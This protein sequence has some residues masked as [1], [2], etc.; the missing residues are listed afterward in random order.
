MYKPIQQIDEEVKRHFRGEGA[1]SQSRPSLTPRSS[2][3][4]CNRMNSETA[5]Y[6]QRLERRPSLSQEHLYERTQRRRYIYAGFALLASLATFVIQTEAVNYLAM[7]LDY[8]KPIFILYVTHSSWFI[9]WPLQV[10]I[11]RV[12]KWRVPFKDFWRYHLA[13]IYSTAVL[14][15]NEQ[16]V[17]EPLS[18]RRYFTR[19]I[20]I[21]TVSLNLAGSSWYLAINLTTAGDLTA[22][23]NCSAFFAY[24]FSV[25]LLKEPFLWDKIFAVLLSIVGVIVVAYAGSEGDNAAKFS[26]ATQPPAPSPPA[27]PSH[28]VEY[29][30]RA[31]GN[32]VIGVG[33]VLYGLYEVL[34]KRLACPPQQVSARR[35]AAFANVV[36][37]A[38]GLCTMCI[39][40]PVIPLFH[41]TGDEKFELPNG[42]QLKVL[43]VSV[44]ANAL[45]SGSF[46]TLM[47]LTSPV[48]SSVAAILTTFLVAIVDWFLFGTQIS[49]GGIFGGILIIIAFV[50]LSYASWKELQEDSDDDESEVML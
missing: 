46:L 4:N 34:Y 23:Y 48:L 27:R 42:D 10:L 39:L 24:A 1:S 32:I 29:P 25:P 26:R 16:A 38:V 31:L 17:T 14:I 11:L 45:F 28:P 37:S 3:S 36:G 2:S 20:L 33:A 9:L 15:V 35:Q 6:T 8:K 49:L 19:V 12:R 41:F 21:I 13:N 47:A 5:L 40:W 30:H 22:I 50:L 43:M 44:V 7:T 18:V